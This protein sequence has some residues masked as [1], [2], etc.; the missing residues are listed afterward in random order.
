MESQKLEK[1]KNEFKYFYNQ[2]G[3]LQNYLNKLT[4]DKKIIMPEFLSQALSIPELD[5]MFLLSLAEKEN[6]VKKLFYVYTKNHD[7]L[8][9]FEDSKKIPDQ[10]Y[11]RSTGDEV[12][13]DNFYID[14]VYKI[15]G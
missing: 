5:A 14:I 12:S 13:E 8:G 4:P 9:E 15:A 1:Y 2:I 7:F 10:I 3:S 11:D 6:L